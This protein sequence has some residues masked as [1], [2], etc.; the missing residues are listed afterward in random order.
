MK[1]IDPDT[2]QR[3]QRI[4]VAHTFLA[5]GS[6][7]SGC[8][9]YE[10]TVKE[11]YGGPLPGVGFEEDASATVSTIISVVDSAKVSVVI[12]AADWPENTIAYADVVV[13]GEE[14]HVASRKDALLVR[15]GWGWIN[16]KDYG[17][18]SDIDIDGGQIRLERLRV[19]HGGKVPA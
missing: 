16:V 5:Q 9:V 14:D 18:Y 13:Q 4:R 17:N 10:G 19:V 6:L 11:L 2:I 12:E 1:T 3:G 15:T 8:A 7:V